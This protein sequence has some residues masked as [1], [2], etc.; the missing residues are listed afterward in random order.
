MPQPDLVPGPLENSP[1]QSETSTDHPQ[2]NKRGIRRIQL[3][4]LVM[5][6][7][8][9]GFG[10]SYWM[11]GRQGGE[12]SYLSQGEDELISV[13]DQINP[14]EGYT[15]P[16]RYGDIGPQ[17]LAA[18]GIDLDRFLKVYEKANQPLT[19]EQLSILTEGSDSAIVINKE[20]AHFL[21][22]FF[23]AVGLDQ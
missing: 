9:L 7:F 19:T 14:P 6:T 17:V 10:S 22:N 20:N 23:W 3:I 5:I 1:A 16:A 8:A 15:L 4:A 13:I 12:N 18:G 11:W 2:H 21:L